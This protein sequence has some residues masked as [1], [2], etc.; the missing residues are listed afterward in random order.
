MDTTFQEQLAIQ[1]KCFHPSGEWEAF[2]PAVLTS[3]LVAR[4]EAMT[5]RYP[6]RPAVKM[7]NLCLTYELLNQQANQI[8]HVVLTQTAAHN[9]PVILLF[10]HTPAAIVALLGVLKAGHFY[11]PFDPTQPAARLIERVVDSG[12]RLLLTDQ[13][14]LALAKEINATS[15]TILTI[16]ALLSTRSLGN[17]GLLIPADAPALLLYTSGSTGRPKG[18]LLTHRA[19]LHRIKRQTEIVHLSCEDRCSCVHTY[20]AIAGLRD[21]FCP[22]LNG[23]M[24]CL[25][26]LKTR[27]LAEL[28]LWLQEHNITILGFVTPTFRQFLTLL[29]PDLDLSKVR[30][31]CIGGDTLYR[32]DVTHYRQAFPPTT[33]LYNSLGATE[34][35]GGFCYYLFDH[36]NPL[37]EDPLPVGYPMI[38]MQIAIADEAGQPRQHGERGEI[39]LTTAYLAQGYWRQTDQT[40]ARFQAN[41]YVYRTGD[42]GFLRADGCLIH[43]GRLDN[44]VKLHGYR[45]ELG[46]VER[47]L[48]RNPAVKEVVVVSQDDQQGEAS[49]VA[50]WVAESATATTDQD[51][52]NWL[53]TQLPSYMIPSHFVR[54][55]MLPLT[56]N[57]KIDRRALQ[58]PA[59][60]AAEHSGPQRAP[61]TPTEQALIHLWSTLLN[62]AP[63]GIDDN[64]FH[65][66]GHSLLM[67]RM[68]M[69][70]EQQF[71]QSLVLR[72]FIFNPTIAHLATLLNPEATP[73]QPSSAEET[74]AFADSD[75]AELRRLYDLL[76][77]KANLEQMRN[78]V[79]HKPAPSRSLQRLLRLPQ[80][81]ALRLL[82]SL[83]QQPWLQS[84]Y[85]ADQ[86]ALIQ[87]FLE[88]LEQP[89]AQG[90]RVAHCLFYGMLNQYGLRNAI[91]QR[92]PKGTIR[93]EGLTRVTQTQA[94]QGIIL[95]T[96]HQYQA[97]YFRSLRL[98][99]GMTI[100]VELLTTRFQENRAT[101]EHILYSRQLELARQAL[102]QGRAI[103]IAPDV[104]RGRGTAIN[105][106]FHGRMHEFR[107]SFAD[108]AILTN[109]QIFFVASELQAYNRFSFH[110]IGPF[111]RGTPAMSYTERVHHLMAQYVAHL[112]EQW[113]RNPWAVPWWLMREHLAYPPA[114]ATMSSS[115]LTNQREASPC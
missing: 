108:L 28:P 3:S 59:A 22:L 13:Q 2:P 105:V 71:Q 35:A 32:Q 89:P 111:D 76:D 6:E 21:L 95:L 103:S 50:Y 19:L 43:L 52:R 90:N 82:Y 51:L 114:V 31:I 48:L 26:D 70:V 96:S 17:P 83:L 7:A 99:R 77:D 29:T 75:E 81:V 56:A 58:P 67:T 54:L 79:R 11:T 68:L 88:G 112:R 94:Q 80:P 106:P 14:H 55:A 16:E 100:S 45:V 72:S 61:R 62:V 53:H 69:Q 5:A 8:A 78:Q 39:T 41:G 66:G 25:F 9:V 57:G 27:P 107:T 64:F 42:S 4:F 60:I 1:A 73:E 97:P 44:Q 20:D 49:L 24:T 23:A 113:A 98:A 46:E 86:T 91:F 15:A 36:Q 102:Q 40:D 109:A 87:Q 92:I 74:T 10:G 47:A 84:R 18:I 37:P 104:N 85:L 110:L 34:T 38:D 12:A 101:A 65:L 33:I 63:I 93:V 115:S 30:L